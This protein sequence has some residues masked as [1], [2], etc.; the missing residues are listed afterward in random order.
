M[1]SSARAHVFAAV[2]LAALVAAALGL[3]AAHLARL[4]AQ[5]ALGALAAAGFGGVVAFHMDLR[6]EPRWVR[7][8]FA[9]PLAFAVL[10]AV[11][12]VADAWSR[13]LRP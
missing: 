10:F 3:R 9:V 4:P 1:T 12:L 11:S 6:S 5:L 8:L 13:G 7:I 2:A